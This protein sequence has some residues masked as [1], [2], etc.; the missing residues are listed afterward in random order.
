MRPTLLL[1][2][3]LALCA[4]PAWADDGQDDPAANMTQIAP[5]LWAI[6]GDGAPTWFSE[7][8]YYVCSAGQWSA[9][10]GGDLSWQPKAVRELPDNI[11]D[12]LDAARYANSGLCPGDALPPTVATAI[13]GP[14][15]MIV[16]GYP[17]ILRVGPYFRG[18]RPSTV[19]V[20]PTPF[21]VHARV[22]GGYARPGYGGGYRGSYST[23]YTG[24]G[25]RGGYGGGGYQGGYRGGY[26]GGHRR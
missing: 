16:G 22:W 23:T 12:G 13:G 20:R 2:G 9:T 3:L 10:P 14:S 4:V 8:Q 6:P 19:W 18:W 26:G 15:V 21:P 5:G 24:S 7:G 11:R 1:T 25:Y 17:R